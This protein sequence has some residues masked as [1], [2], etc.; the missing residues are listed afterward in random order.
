M[1]VDVLGKF[2]KINSGKVLKAFKFVLI[3][4][5]LQSY[6][7]TKESK[8]CSEAMRASDDGAKGKS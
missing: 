8:P 5:N 3:I 4:L 7:M 6:L 2:M 1:F